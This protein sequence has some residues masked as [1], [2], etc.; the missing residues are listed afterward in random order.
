MWSGP[1]NISTALMRSWESRP[2]T[3]VVDEPLYAFYLRETG[4]DHPGREEILAS[5]ANDWQTVAEQLSGTIPGG[6]AIYYQKHMAHHLLPQVGMGWLMDKSFRHAFLIRE[7][8]AML[9]SLS[10]V[11]SNPRV[12]D[13]GLPQQ[14]E[15]FE[16]LR[17]TTGHIPPVVDSRAVLE[18]PKDMLEALC[19]ALDVPFDDAMLSWEAGPR[20][21][22]GVWAE[23]WYANV[24]KSTGFGP[25]RAETAEVPEGLEEVL[26]ACQR[27]YDTLAAHVLAV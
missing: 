27:H 7:P 6:K 13:T 3:A 16:M 20:T 12:E 15:L 17:R 10:K 21:S 2:D 22:D 26:V 19:H 5:Q 23:H 24:E 18:N 14:V 25:P 11:I 8:A 1:R 9:A 4:L